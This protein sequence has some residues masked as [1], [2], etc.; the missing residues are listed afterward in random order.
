[1]AQWLELIAPTSDDSQV[2]LSPVPGDRMPPG[3][4]RHLHAHT[5]YNTSVYTHMNKRV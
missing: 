2:P 5:A 4:H 3:L 1:M